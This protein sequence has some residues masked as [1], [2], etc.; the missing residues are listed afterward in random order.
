MKYRGFFIE[1]S[2]HYRDYKS[3]YGIKTRLI[4]YRFDVYENEHKLIL[5]E[6]FGGTIGDNLPEIPKDCEEYPCDNIADFVKDHIDSMFREY[7]SEVKKY[8]D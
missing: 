3:V 8:G 2:P 4:G 6:S 5:F 7:K 1:I